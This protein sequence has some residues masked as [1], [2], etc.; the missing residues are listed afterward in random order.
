MILPNHT[1]LDQD[2]LNWL[3]EIVPNNKLSESQKKAL[4]F[5]KHSSQMNNAE[6]RRLTAVDSRVA[7]RELAELVDN[8]IL[9]RQ[10]TRRWATYL[11]TEKLQQ[12]P[13]EPITD[14]LFRVASIGEQILSLLASRGPLSSAELQKRIDSPISTVR[15][16]L[17]KL[18]DSGE[19][20]ITTSHANNPNTMYRTKP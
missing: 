3:T 12:G 2:T 20:E 8:G 9:T 17:K 4:A 19:V 15:Y 14:D 5:L 13:Q 10:G 6:Y 16:W 7:T 11:L 18:R 1:L